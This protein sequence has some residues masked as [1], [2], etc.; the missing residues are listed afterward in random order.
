MTESDRDKTLQVMARAM[1]APV[2]GPE[3]EKW[4]EYPPFNRFARL[5]LDA[6]EASGRAVVPVE[7]TREM[8]E[9]GHLADERNYDGSTPLRLVW[10]AMIAASKD[11]KAS[12]QEASAKA[13]SA[14]ANS[15]P[16]VKEDS[17]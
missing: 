8:I 16:V 3:G 13:R 7:P 4:G 9:S 11:G 5:A 6:L 14:V 17:E 10:A 2:E 12:M 1:G 15:K